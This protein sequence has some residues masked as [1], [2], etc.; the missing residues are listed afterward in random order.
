MG[1]SGGKAVVVCRVSK[2]SVSMVKGLDPKTS[3]DLVDEA[4]VLRQYVLC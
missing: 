1:T 4:K 2:G 3:M